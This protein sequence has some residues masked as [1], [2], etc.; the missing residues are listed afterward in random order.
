MLLNE[1]L[2]STGVAKYYF[3]KIFLF[4][5]KYIIVDQAKFL[6]ITNQEFK[7]INSFFP[8]NKIN[9]ISNPIPFQK[10]DVESLQKKK[11]FVYFGRIHPHKN[12]DLI[13]NAFKSSNLN[14]E[15]KLKIYGLMMMQIILKNYKI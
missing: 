4:F 12:I 10:E 15:W 14:N 9:V 6:A 11:Q 2:K 3:K 1:A 7:A 8:K 5:F 13:I